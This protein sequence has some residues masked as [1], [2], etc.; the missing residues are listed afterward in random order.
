MAQ[1]TEEAAKK[2]GPTRRSRVRAFAMIGL[3]LLLSILL[4][5]VN[6]ASLG[7]YGYLG[8][9]LI[10]L[11]GNATVIV[12]APAFVTAFAAGRTL[13]PWLVG[14]IS[15]VGA[16]IGETTGY[17]VGRAGRNVI[18]EHP[19]FMRITAQV[20]R[21]GA[22]AVFGFAVIP[23][24]LMDVAGMAAGVLRLPFWKYLLACSAG[25]IIRF[26]ILALIGHYGWQP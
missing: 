3:M 6:F 22:W 14:G 11:L 8:V 9:F 19:K 2:T 15:G 12:P 17:L 21:W 23:N 18:G 25:K 4:L 1:S 5:Q 7:E 16:G 13:N 26:T 20:K 24:P 10:V